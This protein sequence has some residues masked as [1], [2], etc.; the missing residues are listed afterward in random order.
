L[1]KLLHSPF[2]NIN[3]VEAAVSFSIGSR[4]RIPRWLLSLE[5][6]PY[7]PINTGTRRFFC[8][9]ASVL[10]FFGD[11]EI[12]MALDNH[13]SETNKHPFMQRVQEA[14]QQ[15]GIS[16]MVF[17]Q[18]QADTINSFKTRNAYALSIDKIRDGPIESRTLIDMVHTMSNLVRSFGITINHMSDQITGLQATINDAGGILQKV[19]DKKVDEVMKGFENLNLGHGQFRKEAQQEEEQHDKDAPPEPITLSSHSNLMFGI[20]DFKKGRSNSINRKQKT[21]LDALH[22]LG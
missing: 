13:W 16:D 2:K 6:T 19:V 15:C 18:W 12:C 9:M 1:Q 5:M 10:R 4:P 17:N 8:S 11:F 7:R 22:R 20:L 3:N 21:R 14:N